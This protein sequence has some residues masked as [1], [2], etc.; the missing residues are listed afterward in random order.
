M[1]WSGAGAGYRLYAGHR[2]GRRL[3]ATNCRTL[4]GFPVSSFLGELDAIVCCLQNTMTLTAGCPIYLHTD[5]ISVFQKLSACDVWYKSRFDLRV[6]RHLGWLWANFPLKS[7]L[8]LHFLPSSDN[9]F[10]NCL[11]RWSTLAQRKEVD[12]NAVGYDG[13]LEKRL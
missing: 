6:G 5:S 12:L 7:R 4:R 3:L 13:E 2:S 9:Y 11:S 8:F 1:D 10:A